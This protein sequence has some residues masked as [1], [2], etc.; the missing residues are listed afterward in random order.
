MPTLIAG[1]LGAIGIGA[2]VATVAGYVIAGLGLSLVAQKLFGPKIPDLSALSRGGGYSG[3]PKRTQTA[4][5]TQPKWVVGEARVGGTLIEYTEDP[6]DKYILTLKYCIS[7]GHCQELRQIYIDG[8]E[9]LESGTRI[10]SSANSEI[11]EHLIEKYQEKLT[12]K[13]IAHSAGFTIVELTLIQPDYGLD[14]K[15]EG[16]NF[17]KRFWTQVPQVSFHVL[18]I[19][20]PTGSGWNDYKSRWDR[21]PQNAALWRYWY[22][23]TIARKKDAD[24]ADVFSAYSTCR[25]QGYKINGVFGLGD[26]S[27]QVRAELD[28]CWQGS[29]VDEGGNI[30]FKPGYYSGA[31]ATIDASK[32]AVQFLGGKPGPILSERYNKAKCTLLQ[33]HE[34][35]FLETSVPSVTHAGALTVDT[36]ERT[37]DLGRRVFVND[38]TKARQLMAIYLR[39]TRA[40]KLYGYRLLPSNNPNDF[41]RFDLYSGD[42][43]KLIDEARGINGIFFVEATSINSDWSVTINLR[44]YISGTYDLTLYSPRVREPYARIP[45]PND[46]VDPPTGL[47]A[48]VT[49]TA[50]NNLIES[51]IDVSWDAS[52]NRT[53]VIIR[54]LDDN[55]SASQVVLGDSAT[56]IVPTPQIYRVTARHRTIKH[57]DSDNVSVD[58]EVDW[59]EFVADSPKNLMASVSVKLNA[60]RDL[61]I[62]LITISWDPQPGIKET[63]YTITGTDGGEI[64]GITSDSTIT[65]PVTSPQTYRIAVH[66]I[67]YSGAITETDTVSAVI[68]WEKFRPSSPTNLILTNQSKILADESV[69][70]TIFAD[71]DDDHNMVSAQINTTGPGFASELFSQ[72]SSTLIQIPTIGEYDVTVKM[73]GAAGLT[74]TSDISTI[75]IDNAAFIP[76]DPK[77]PTLDFLS[78][79]V[80]DGSMLSQADKNR[81]WWFKAFPS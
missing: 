75:T 14:N 62:S 38:E 12:G 1:W 23:R 72:L 42:Y 6:D 52:A 7:E 19:S 22:E 18:G 43:V 56:F 48:T 3:D 25:T 33:S 39:R 11:E 21:D 77:N 47:M 74:G 64:T 10:K 4:A 8:E 9:T 34:D 80:S 27:D 15:A 46:P 29:V 68:S 55:Y 26:P 40:N 61:I 41:T 59:S 20:W 69:K 73:I 51:K 2:G 49:N 44:E 37:I 13:F 71:W 79:I 63:G 35:R 24:L 17:D 57:I 66:H 78:T 5:V 67:S 45:R 30:A 36:T 54:G 53:L 81:R 50:V 58:V 76:P 65:I 31:D 60:T 16:P 70:Y 32:S 28:W